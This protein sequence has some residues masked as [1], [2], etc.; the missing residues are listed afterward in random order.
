M[1]ENPTLT[2]LLI[3]EKNFSKKPVWKILDTATQKHYYLKMADPKEVAMTIKAA[4]L[5]LP[6]DSPVTIPKAY[7]TK[8]SS[9]PQALQADISEWRKSEF[10]TKDIERG[11]TQV[12]LTEAVET[13]IS[14]AQ[15]WLDNPGLKENVAIALKGK[16]I[17][18]YEWHT[19]EKA[20]QAMNQN[21]VFNHDLGSNAFVQRDAAGKFHVNIIDFQPH[22]LPKIA[23]EGWD[24][25]V[26]RM[27]V[28]KTCLITSGA[29]ESPKTTRHTPSPAENYSS[30]K[31]GLGISP[32]EIRERDRQ[33]REHPSKIT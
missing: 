4:S 5:T 7:E 12:L 23:P 17:T 18:A 10:G 33:M 32:L 24:E 29:M 20:V 13:H 2:N 31:C 15:L 8:L 19:F 28:F 11:S 3:E 21:G 25:D 27:K 30:Q 16:P 9:L 22:L 1:S 14:V 26:D 6:P